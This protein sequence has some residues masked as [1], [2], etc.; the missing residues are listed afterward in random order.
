MQKRIILNSP[1]YHAYIYTT[2]GQDPNYPIVGEVVRI[3]G[4]GHV[5]TQPTKW[6]VE[7]KCCLVIGVNFSDNNFDFNPSQVFEDN[8]ISLEVIKH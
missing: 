7:G 6:S 4:N 8:V 1:Y 2:S 3:S 5:N